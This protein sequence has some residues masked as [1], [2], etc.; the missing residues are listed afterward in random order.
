MFYICVKLPS[1]AMMSNVYHVSSSLPASV[2]RVNKN[3][4]NQCSRRCGPL[5]VECLI[6]T[7]AI[8]SLLLY[9][10]LSFFTPIARLANTYYHLLI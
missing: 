6:C 9:Q 1:H 5:A 3:L 4:Q 7:V 2:A 10:T 8:I